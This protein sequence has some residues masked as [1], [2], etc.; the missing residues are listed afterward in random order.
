MTPP[1]SGNMHHAE[2]AVILIRSFITERFWLHSDLDDGLRKGAAICHAERPPS[3][4]GSSAQQG[5]V[6]REPLS[7]VGH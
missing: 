3:P 2:A 6:L 1:H 7:W 5:F 4:N